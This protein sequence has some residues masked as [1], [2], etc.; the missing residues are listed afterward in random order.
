ML[1]GVLVEGV[2]LARGWLAGWLRLPASIV[3][4]LALLVR[5]PACL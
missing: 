1:A 2:R 4:L 5:L 3:G